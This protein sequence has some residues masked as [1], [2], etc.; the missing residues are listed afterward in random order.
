MFQQLTKKGHEQQKLEPKPGGTGRYVNSDCR[1]IR[2]RGY[3]N[4]QTSKSKTCLQSAC[5]RACMRVCVCACVRACVRV[6]VCARV[7]ECTCYSSTLCK[8]SRHVRGPALYISLAAYE[9]VETNRAAGHSSGEVMES[10]LHDSQ[11]ILT[12]PNTSNPEPERSLTPKPTT[13][14]PEP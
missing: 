12:I 11:N 14:S 4:V 9:R 3:L 8:T 5:V 7:R 6:C 2:I 10:T 13:P 1:L